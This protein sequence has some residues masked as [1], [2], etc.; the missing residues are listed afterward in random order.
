MYR[1]LQLQIFYEFI[2]ILLYYFN[3]AIYF[4]Y[5]FSR[6]LSKFSINNYFI[7]LYFKY[8]FILKCLNKCFL[9]KNDI[10]S[11]IYILIIYIGLVF[12][13]I[14]IVGF[15]FFH[16]WFYLIVLLIILFLFLKICYKM[17]DDYKWFIYYRKKRKIV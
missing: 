6:I 13:M 11:A 3:H 4:I 2:N 12:L 1:V 14:I 16:L 9:K 17:K 7:L 8:F 5:W 10:V 15:T